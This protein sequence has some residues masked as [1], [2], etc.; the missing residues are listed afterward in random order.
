MKVFRRVRKQVDVLE[1]P[2]RW[3]GE[4]FKIEI[5][6]NFGTP[7]ATGTSFV[8][9]ADLAQALIKSLFDGMRLDDPDSELPIYTVEQD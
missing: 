8:L 4:E 1:I 5:T 7:Q 3:S 2:T 6:N 9:R